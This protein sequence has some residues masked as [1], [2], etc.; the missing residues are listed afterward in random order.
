MKLK[1]PSPADFMNDPEWASFIPALS[2]G[3]PKCRLPAH[4]DCTPLD[5]ESAARHLEPGGT[6]GAMKGYEARPGQL[7]M[8]RAI[9][10]ACNDRCHLMIEAGTG[11]GKSL[12]YLVPSV[13]WSHLNDTPVVI[14][15]ATRNLQ[16]QLTNA[17]LPRAARVLGDD[18][19]KL[20]WAVLKGRVNYL[21]L[22]ALEEYMQGGWWTLSPDEQAEF[23]RFLDWLY[24]TEDGDL[25]AFGGEELRARL[26]CPSED[27]WGRACRYAD[28]CFV[29]KARARALRAHIIVANH[30]LVLSEAANPGSGLLPAY[31]RLVFDEAH[32]LEDIATDYFSY[33]LSKPAL[34]KTLGRLARPG[35]ARRGRTAHTRGLLGTIERQL[36]KVVLKERESAE[37][38]RELVNRAHIQS[39]FVSAA[40]DELFAVLRR[41]FAP[42]RKAD[43]LRYRTIPSPLFDETAAPPPAKPPRLRQYCLNGLFADYT[44]AQWN[45]AE[46]WEAAGRLE[47]A[48]AKLQDIVQRLGV[49]LETAADT[50]PVLGEIAAQAQGLV[51]Q[52]TGFIL[53]SKCVLEAADAERVFW[54]EKTRDN[55]R[56]KGYLRLVGAPLSIAKEMKRCFYDVKDTVVMCSATLRAGDKFDYMARKLGL[57][58]VA[59]EPPDE[60][61]AAAERVRALVAA[62][63][64]DYFRQALV[65]AP[66]CLPDPAEAS[67]VEK[68]VPFLANLFFTTRGRALVL[69]TS[70]DMMNRAAELARPAFGDQGLTLFVQGEGLS[71]EQMVEKLKADANTVLFG[72]QSF[73]E[74]VDVPGEAL[75]CVVLA[76]LPFPQVG[77]PIT[78]ARGER[79]VER[80]GSEFR[81]FMMPEALIRFRQGFGRL[82]RTKRDRGVVVITDARLARK[83]YGAVFRKSLAASVHT[84]TSLEEVLS[85]TA[86]FFS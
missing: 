24:A 25:D 57:D 21:C 77:D 83:N 75:S 55:G 18:A 69:F 47:D 65:M 80:G 41:L 46:A 3:G 10:R 62:S 68:L 17:D 13:L 39:G 1:P 23:Q 34:M 5:V 85:R 44:S 72:A 52:F 60:E 63:P 4:A 22:R 71:R 45:E 29:A 70:Y 50:A 32:N 33:E 49:A 48:L 8:L 56:E 74:G 35:R 86:D 54:V 53:E 2:N 14:S 12:A 59:A 42:A 51:A 67:Y 36:A 82:V 64:F 16:S 7:D 9:V 81:D 30:A 40:A 37:N 20:R 11:V 27:C 43:I 28:K 73:W 78:E 26:C 15:T 31:G 19:G 58:L 66:D 6:L 38:I 76:R 84:V 79:I 61:G